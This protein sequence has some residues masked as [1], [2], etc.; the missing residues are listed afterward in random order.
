MTFGHLTH[1]L[2]PNTVW[3]LRVG[4][5]VWNQENLPSTGSLE[6]ASRFDRV[7]GVTSGAP[8][9]FGGLTL[10]RTTAKGTINRYQPALL[11]AD[12]QWRIGAQVEKGEHNQPSIIPTG[13]R[14]VDSA[15][16]PFQS[17]ASEP[18]NAG[19]VFITA[20]G[21]ISDAITLGNM[22]TI[23]AG[24]RFDH[25]RAISQ[26]LHALDREGNET[27]DIVEGLGT[28]YTWNVW[29][30]RIGVTMKLSADG[31]TMLR[32]SYG[33]FTQGVLSGELSPFHP[34]ATPTTTAAFDPATS[35]YTTIVS[36]VDPRRNLQ[37]DGGMRAPRT[38]EYSI[39]V[40]RELGRRLALAVAYV[41]KDGATSSGGLMSVGSI[42]RNHGRFPTAGPCRCWC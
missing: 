8:P 34:G 12:H 33:R 20:A 29:S 32:G 17:I 35:G 10:I 4:R 42:A 22:L 19:G 11:G 31:R 39:G 21:F 24:V 9:A 3:D 28:L 6:T 18:S 40:D 38:D 37:L 5:F 25:S 26:D 23:N 13:V 1:T 41:R 7:T 27:G 14:Y 15:G 2:S 16:Q 36:V 30:P